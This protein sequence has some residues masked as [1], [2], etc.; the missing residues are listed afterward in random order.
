MTGAIAEVRELS[1]SFPI[2]RSSREIV[3]RVPA[4]SVDAV[5]NVSFSITPGE[6]VALVGESGSGKTTTAQ[7]LLGLLD[8]RHAV[9]SGTIEFQGRDVSSF[10]RRQARAGRQHRQLVY[11]DPYESL[12]GRLRVSEIVREP[13]DIHRIGRREERREKAEACLEQV[14]LDPATVMDRYPH[15]LSGGE[16]QRVAIASALVLEPR[17]IV[18][19]EPVSML[20]MSVRAGVLAVLAAVRRTGVGILMI[21]HDLSTVAHHA[22]RV[23]VMYRGEMVEQGAAKA[24][25]SDPQHPYTKALIS[26]VPS[27]DPRIKGRGELLGGV[28][29]DQE[30]AHILQDAAGLA[31][32]DSAEQSSSEMLE[33]AADLPGEMPP[34]P[35]V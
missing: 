32:V 24:V 25:V 34:H 10:S 18:A 30:I 21:T 35:T 11:Q 14:G 2:R 3:R 12:D 13:L 23:C 8:P 33:D 5:K 17:L 1:V 16:R 9:V 26:A 28:A 7:A 22:D 15:Q 19:D 6:T 31:A 29:E 27:I 4:R 20:D